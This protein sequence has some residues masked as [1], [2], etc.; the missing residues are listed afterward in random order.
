MIEL[1]EHDDAG[2]AGNDEAVTF[3]VVGT[4]RHLGPVVEIRRHGVH[5]VEQDGQRPVEL[6]AAAGKHDILLAQLDELGAIADAVRAGRAGRGDRITHAL[7]VV[8]RRQRGRVGRGHGLRHLEGAHLFRALLA[9]VIGGLHDGA[10]RG[11]A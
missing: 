4:A 8:G 2:T 10:G 1:L 6:L 11:P 7:D 9:G 5:G 3:G